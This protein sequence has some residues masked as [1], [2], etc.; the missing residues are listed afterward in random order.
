MRAPLSP[1]ALTIALAL[2]LAACSATNP[3]ELGT[4][5]GKKPPLAG[6]SVVIA[7]DKKQVTFTTSSGAITRAATPWARDKW[8][9]LCPRGLKDTSSEVLDLGPEPLEIG[10]ARVDHPVLVADCLHRPSLD[11]M[12]LGKDGEPVKPGVGELWR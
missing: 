8:P 4:Y 9:T 6:V 7:T 10:G 5:T 12:S 3:I 1:F 2:P 11:L